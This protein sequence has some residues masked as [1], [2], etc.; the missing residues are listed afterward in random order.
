MSATTVEAATADAGA[1]SAPLEG[2]SNWL[3][4]LL[5]V[6][7]PFAVIYALAKAMGE[8]FPQWASFIHDF[9]TT[10]GS[11]SAG[12][13]A[14]ALESAVTWFRNTELLGLI[15]GRDLIRA[16]VGWLDYPLDFT[17]GLLIDG[18]SIFGFE[19]P[20]I[21]WLMLVGIA[22]VV[23]HWAG[24]WKLALL[25][26]GTIA[27]FAIFD[28]W[29]VS[30]V[31]FSTVMVTAPLSVLLGSALGLWAARSR[32]FESLLTPNLN[33]MQSMPH[34]AYFIPIAVFVG[35]SHKAGVVATILFAIPPMAK[36]ATLGIRGVSSEVLDA[37][38]MSGANKRQMLWKVE[39]PAAKESLMVGVNQVIMQCL[40]MTVLA[41]LVGTRGLGQILLNK[42][43]ALRV[44]E[45]LEMGMAIV[46]MAIMLDR[47]SQAASRRRPEHQE[48]GAGFVE[49]HPHAVAFLGVFVVT[50]I[51][52]LVFSWALT[53]PES[54]T[55]DWTISTA[56][57]WEAIVDWVQVELRD[58][59]QA[60]KDF[61]LLNMLLPMRDFF[62]AI[63]WT[64]MLA[65]VMAVGWK[66]G[67]VR[68]ALIVGAFI[69]FIAVAGFWV[70]AMESLYLAMA[71]V[72]IAVVFGVPVGILASRYD[73]SYNAMQVVLDTFQTLP[74]FIYLIPVVMLFN[75]GAVAALAAILIYSFVPAVRYTM[76]GLRGVPHEVVEA[77]DTSGCT[78]LQRLLKVK[79]PLAMPEIMLGVNQ[80][81]MFSLLMVMIAA[82]IGGIDGLGDEILLALRDQEAGK[83]VIVGLCLAALGLATD[84][85][86]V[87]WSRERKKQLGLA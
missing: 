54:D 25:G 31:T 73:W 2:R 67:R 58:V 16:S 32:R 65:L 62:V 13:I 29:E 75:V 66:I 20:P 76:L 22:A 84:Q 12:P 77:A 74:A 39:I 47:I 52:A 55:R 83:G 44:G 36:L 26:G 68:L 48:E 21:P 33:V 15:T 8:S 85:L 41:S 10:P 18:N 79:L 69:A 38:H 49:R 61:F 6:L 4:T 50:S 40:G 59:T 3:P 24:G 86:I 63:P 42:L 23:G 71:S 51:L 7:G 46:L 14:D 19:V 53:Y 70:P 72:V 78:P 64:A 34:F 56:P 60:I 87:N 81:L 1:S 17:E 11:D 27:Y 57:F 9:R 30:M 28:L 37:G 45:A 43:Q 5:L 82:L 35:I 80:V